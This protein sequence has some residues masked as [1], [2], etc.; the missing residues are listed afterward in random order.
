ME[1]VN[2]NTQNGS[3]LEEFKICSIGCGDGAL[4][5]HILSNLVKL[6]PNVKFHYTGI[7]A[8]NEICEVAE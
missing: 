1:L 4:D 2:A 3:C 5:R 7:D 8:D 6:F